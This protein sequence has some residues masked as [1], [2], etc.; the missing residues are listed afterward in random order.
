MCFTLWSF[1]Y[2]SNVQCVFIFQKT[3]KSDI[4]IHISEPNFSSLFIIHKYVYVS[5]L[6][7]RI[8]KFYI[9]YPSSGGGTNKCQYK[10]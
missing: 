7:S 2:L 1:L 9:N 4:V 6:L 3:L 10:C 8:D 5:Q